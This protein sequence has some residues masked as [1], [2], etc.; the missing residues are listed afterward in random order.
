M[1][2][3]YVE[4]RDRHPGTLINHLSVVMYEQY[5]KTVKNTKW[6]M[7]KW[8]GLTLMKDPMSL[9]IYQQ[10]LQDI[11]FKTIIE[12]GTFDGGSALWMEDI[13]KT[14]GNECVIHT[15]DNDPNNVKLPET[16]KVVYHDFD[17]NNIEDFDKNIL[18]NLVHP[19]L[20]IEDSHANV[21]NSLSFIDKYLKNGDYLI[22]EDTIYSPYIPNDKYEDSHKFASLGKY[23]V[24]SKYCDMWGY[25]NSWNMNTILIKK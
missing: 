24:D 3:R 22:I 15:I 18:N 14:I 2:N 23:M 20:V 21:F 25:N 12:F 10:M 11:K 4:Y 5:M 7:Q 17:M 13:N 9:T 19:I 16:S 6:N 8:R 1:K